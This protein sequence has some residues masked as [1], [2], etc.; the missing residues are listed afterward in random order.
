MEN[1]SIGGPIRNKTTQPPVI[2]VMVYFFYYN[3]PDAWQVGFNPTIIYDNE[4][5]SGN[6]WNVPVGIT[7]GKMMKFGQ[8][9]VKIQVGFEYA[10]VQQDDY[11]AEWRFKIDFIPNIKPL[12][13]GD[14]F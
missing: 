5:S 8:T 3:F 2:V 1:G 11:G 6:K 4:A 13:S 10:A 12:I 9:P 14:L 7:A